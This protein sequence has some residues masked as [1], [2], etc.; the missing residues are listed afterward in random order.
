M[1]ITRLKVVFA[2]M[3]ILGTL[4]LAVDAVRLRSYSGNNLNFD[5]GGG[6]VTVTNRS[7][8]PVLVQFVGA[9]SGSFS[10][11]NVIEGSLGAS[12]LQSTG[13]SHELLEVELPAGISEFT[14]I[15]RTTATPDINFAAHSPVLLYVTVQ[16]LNTNQVHLVI[17]ASTVIIL[18]ALLYIFHFAHHS[19]PLM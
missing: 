5:I 1:K 14:V 19:Q 3:I 10:V 12:V 4:F 13:S 2:L 15:D 9:G 6:A 11:S 7:T 17:G 16:P 8:Q 18:G